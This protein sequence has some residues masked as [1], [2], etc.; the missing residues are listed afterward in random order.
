MPIDFN[1]TGSTKLTVGW[2]PERW[3]IHLFEETIEYRVHVYEG[4]S[5]MPVRELNA[6]A[7]ALSRDPRRVTVDGLQENTE[8]TI[9]VMSR[10]LCSDY[11]SAASS[12]RLTPRDGVPPANPV[13]EPASYEWLESASAASACRVRVY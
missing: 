1:E 10:V 3:A 11:E 7:D 9:N 8:Y 4:S 12:I 2:Q 13:V 5:S 6:S